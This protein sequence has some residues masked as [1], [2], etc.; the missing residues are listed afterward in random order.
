MRVKK[1]LPK[2]QSLSSA[3]NI[4]LAYMRTLLFQDMTVNP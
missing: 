3:K 1:I 4:N 2:I